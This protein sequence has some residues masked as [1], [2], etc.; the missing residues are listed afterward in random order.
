VT[1]DGASGW[2]TYRVDRHVQTVDTQDV[3]SG[4]GQLGLTVLVSTAQAP[5]VLEHMLETGAGGPHLADVLVVTTIGDVGFAWDADLT[6][7][8]DLDRVTTF[9]NHRLAHVFRQVRVV[10]V[11]LHEIALTH[12][13]RSEAVELVGLGT[14]HHYLRIDAGVVGE[15]ILDTTEGAA[16][17][18][19]G[20]LGAVDEG[21]LGDVGFWPARLH[22]VRARAHTVRVV[23]IDERTHIA[24][25]FREGV[26][27]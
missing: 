13:K 6:D 5:V 26:A 19:F 16:L 4:R 21:T 7:L 3:V 8:L 11:S 9:G 24:A 12:L 20:T 27:M 18:H 25:I 2:V 14:A 10:D 17:N 15:V 23:T 22:A 1:D